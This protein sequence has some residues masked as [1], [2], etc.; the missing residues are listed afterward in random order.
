MANP[1]AASSDWSDPSL[2]SGDDSARTCPQCG[3]T[4]L[5]TRYCTECAAELVPPVTVTH[6][7]GPMW[8]V[9]GHV[10][11][12]SPG[13]DVRRTVLDAVADMVNA[14]APVRVV[15][16]DGQLMTKVVLRLDGSS[17]AQGDDSATWA[18]PG[19]AVIPPTVTAR[20]TSI[21]GVHPGAGVSTWAELLDLP[22]AELA[23]ELQGPVVL[24]CR[25]T[26]AGINATKAA[27][28]SL[29][30]AAVDAVL[31]VADAPGK[32]VP[33]AAREQRV[34][35]GAVPVVPVPWLP[36]LRAVAE[37]SPA[38]AGQLARPVQ[39]VTKALLGAQSMKEKAE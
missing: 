2:T 39:R 22:E 35:A 19:R 38:L 32:P 9:N 25:S 30:P 1:A 29:G 31:V 13:E 26:P 4:R 18:G 5:G 3:S 12:V 37:I 7:I 10:L 6:A 16:A 33:A 24:V 28:H 34:L 11:T 15:V 36:R 8:A 27:I 20:R 23:N 17:V 21:V 14:T